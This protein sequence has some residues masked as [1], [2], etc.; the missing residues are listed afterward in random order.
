MTSP[1]PS[2]ESAESSKAANQFCL[3]LVLTLHPLVQ[4][5][6][7][8]VGSIWSAAKPDLN[9]LLASRI[10]QGM[11]MAPTESIATATIGDLYFVHQRGMRIAIWGLSLLGG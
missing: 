9:N 3:C 6:F 7:L 1:F 10:I 4:A 8:L 5:V 2:S 11:G